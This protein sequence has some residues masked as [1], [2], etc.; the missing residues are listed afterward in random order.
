MF[1]FTTKK[2]GTLK[3]LSISGNVECRQEGEPCIPCFQDVEIAEILEDGTLWPFQ[4][5]GTTWMGRPI[6]CEDTTADIFYRITRNETGT[7]QL[8]YM[9]PP[10]QE[11]VDKY[12]ALG[13]AIIVNGREIPKVVCYDE[14]DLMELYIDRK[15]VV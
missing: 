14:Q 4:P 5:S 9:A 3:T 1:D 6:T 11:L 12:R 10:I 15:S 7:F 8:L 2:D 13:T